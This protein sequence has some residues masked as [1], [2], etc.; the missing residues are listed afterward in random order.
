MKKCRR[1]IDTIPDRG[2]RTDGQTPFGL[3]LGKKNSNVQARQEITMNGNRMSTGQER[4]RICTAARAVLVEIIDERYEA[5][6][7]NRCPVT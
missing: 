1:Y 5:A 4:R 3:F 2:R 6:T 7:P